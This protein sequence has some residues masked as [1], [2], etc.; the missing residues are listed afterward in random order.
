[1][2]ARVAGTPERVPLL[3]KAEMKNS[4]SRFFSPVA[5]FLLFYAPAAF[6]VTTLKQ[7]QVSNGSQVDLLFDGKVAKSQIHT[8]F[9]NDI[10]QISLSDV[11]VYP[12]KIST[13]NSGKLTKIFAY[14]YAPKLVRCRLSVKGKAEDFKDGI[15]IHSSGKILT[16][17]LEPAEQTSH[18]GAKSDLVASH[19]AQATHAQEASGPRIDEVEERALLERVLKNPPAALSNEAEAPAQVAAPAAAQAAKP[20]NPASTEDLPISLPSHPLPGVKPLPSP[21]KAMGKMIGVL[22]LF[23]LLAFA[24]KK[25]V[26][27]Q[28][29]DNKMLG[30]IGRFARQNLGR[31]GKMIEVVSNHYLGPKKSIAVVKVAG[32]MLVLGITNENINLITQISGD[33]ADDLESGT[34]IEDF[35]SFGGSRKGTGA[36][37]GGAAAVFS[38]ILTSE[39]AKPGPVASPS[40]AP[41]PSL[42]NELAQTYGPSVRNQIKSRLEGLKPL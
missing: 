2:L 39:T 28:K 20:A 10:I 36:T 6:A 8:E 40:R 21:M 13:V 42:S 22:A 33:A 3:R 32:R 38:D 30:A 18:L 17:R 11:S 16:V 15:D 14:Q 1:M 29:S 41:S 7:V 37:A 27:E 5:L 35:A 34:P 19:A 12:A 26:L 24:F 31:Q 9:F 4:R 25:Y 23:G